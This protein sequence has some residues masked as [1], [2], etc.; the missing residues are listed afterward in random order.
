VSASALLNYS[1]AQIV[2]RYN[3]GFS[4]RAT[5]ALANSPVANTGVGQQHAWFGTGA[6]APTYNPFG[7]YAP[8]VKPFS[9]PQFYFQNRPLVT[10]MDMARTE[11]LRGLNYG[12]Y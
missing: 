1:Y 8:P 4:P 5:L 6:G 11:V 10:S 9:Y 12:L 2:G 7:S 3:V